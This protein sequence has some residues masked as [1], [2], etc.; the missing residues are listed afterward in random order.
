[1]ELIRWALELGES[2]H[3]NTYEELMPLLDYYYDRDHLK[4]YFVANLLIDMDVAEEHREK[5][6]LRRCIAA[7]YAG[8]YKVAK[9]HANE[10]LLKYPDVDLYKNNLRLMEAYLNKEYDYCLFICPKTY[11]SFI[12]VARALKWR[13]EQE[14]NTAIISETILEN[15]KNTIVFGA[16][17]YAHNPNLLPKN[18]IIY[19]LEQLYEG[20]PYAHPFYLILLKDKE[21]WDYSKQNIEWLKQKG[22]GKEI[23]HVGMNYAPTLEIKKDAFD[24]EIT[25]DIDILFIGALNSR[26]QA[27]LDQ[28]KAVAPNLNIVFK[29]NA[30]GIARNELIARSK[31]ILNIHFYLSG[32]LETPRVSYAV[33]NKKFIISENSNPEDEMEWP[34]I[35]F[36]SYEKIIENILKYISLPE[37]RIKLAE[38]AYTHFEANGSRGIL[39]HNGEES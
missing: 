29:N 34:G 4:A 23:K 11:G 31:I 17:T 39:S 28:L 38:K 16:H 15:V 35:V 30:W 13:L 37:E 36:T 32:I 22:I 33:A 9:K 27:I 6:E 21:I 1:M 18:A 8:M 20:S 7:Y 2:V 10:L 24:D 14:G 25:E 26:R 3:G 5:I 19:N 12:D